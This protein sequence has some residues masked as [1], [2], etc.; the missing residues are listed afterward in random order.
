[1]PKIKRVEK[2]RTAVNSLVPRPAKVTGRNPAAFATGNN[3][4]KYKYG[5]SRPRAITM[6]YS[7]ENM[8]IQ[9][10]MA[11]K[12]GRASPRNFGKSW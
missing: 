9:V 8:M 10:N 11:T 2:M 3:K 5:M 7:C 6:I 4:R 1:M 12:T